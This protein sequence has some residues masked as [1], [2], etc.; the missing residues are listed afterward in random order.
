MSNEITNVN[1]QSQGFEIVQNAEGKYERKPIYKPFSSVTAETREEKI[2]LMNLLDGDLALPMND[3]VGAK[4]NLVDVIFKPY[5]SINEETGEITYGVL[6]YLFDIDGD[7]YVTSSKSVYHSLQN[8]FN[9]FGQPSYTEEDA[10]VLEVVKKQGFNN[11]YV[12][13]KLIG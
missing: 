2:R 10:L 6:S 5:D 1:Y 12:D 13:I 8:I 7:V 3:N 4:I 11:K 9:V